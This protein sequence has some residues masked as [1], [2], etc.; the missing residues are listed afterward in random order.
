MACLLLA[1]AAGLSHAVHAVDESC[2]L[3]LSVIHLPQPA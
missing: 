3:C 1:C 2:E